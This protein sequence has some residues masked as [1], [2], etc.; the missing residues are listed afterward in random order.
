MSHFFKERLKICSRTHD[1]VC[2]MVYND[3]DRIVTI[4]ERDAQGNLISYLNY[5]RDADG[6]IASEFTLP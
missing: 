5:E 2:D 6:K 1:T 3:S 4:T